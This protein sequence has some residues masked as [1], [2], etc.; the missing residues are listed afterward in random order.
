LASEKKKGKSAADEA[1]RGLTRTIVNWLVL[2]A[3][4]AILVAW[5]WQGVYW[6]QPGESA[7]ILQLGA[8][9]RIRS[10]EGWAWHLPPPLESHEVVNTSQLRTESFGVRP[11]RSTPG[12][13][14]TDEQA[15]IAEQIKRDAI[16]TV[17]NNIVNVAYEL[18]YVVQ[19]AYSYRFSM[20]DPGSILH[21][22]TEAAMRNVIGKRSID[23]VL[24]QDRQEIEREAEQV[25]A[26]LLVTYVTEVGH[27]AAFS[28]GKIN[29]E[30]VQAPRAVRDAF[31]DVV[32][33]AQDEKRSSLLATGDSQEILQRAQS[34]AAEIREQ[35]EAYRNAKIIEAKGEASR[36]EALLFEYQAAPEVT[37]SRLY[38]ETME[39]ILPGVEK[40]VVEPNT[41]NMLPML[42][43]GGQA[44]VVGGAR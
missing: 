37:R 17:D 16:Q 18:Q 24:S 3:S 34:E 26:A 11:T 6:L 4:I 1:G 38:L 29:L 10:I 14:T 35:A 13:P 20:A 40:M 30:E 21:D 8:F 12:D 25:L 28:I 33:A 43:L 39:E 5:G 44:P 15:D 9:E 27:E 36:F 7:V 2:A 23:A 19:D 31:D 22:T 42:P 41:V 32:S